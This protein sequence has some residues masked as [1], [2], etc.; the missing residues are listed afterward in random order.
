MRPHHTTPLQLGRPTA[1]LLLALFSTGRWLAVSSK[2]TGECLNPSLQDDGASPT[3]R[4]SSKIPLRCWSDC[5]K[6]S[7]VLFCCFCP[8][9]CLKI[10][11]ADYC[12]RRI[13]LL[14]WL[15][16]W[17]FYPPNLFPLLAGELKIIQ[18]WQDD[19]F[20]CHFV[21][22]A[23]VGSP[24]CCQLLRPVNILVFWLWG[25]D[26]TTLESFFTT[27]GKCIDG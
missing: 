5:E 13:F 23:F 9:F 22:F 11:V 15:G 14:F 12:S 18:R 25:F 20:C 1:W 3:S 27:G 19:E 17:W 6:V 16:F 8:S 10:V 7:R 4:S 26:K 21:V 24:I 2:R